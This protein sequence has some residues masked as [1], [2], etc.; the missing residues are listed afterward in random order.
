MSISHYNFVKSCV[1]LFLFVQ[2][3]HITFTV[4]K[5][6]LLFTIS[7]CKNTSIDQPQEM[8]FQRYEYNSRRYEDPEKEESYQE[9][10][11]VA[12]WTQIK[13]IP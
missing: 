3:T 4:I 2:Q 8:C 1:S 13:S 11:L 7:I 10:H 6:K 9:R 5:A 12:N